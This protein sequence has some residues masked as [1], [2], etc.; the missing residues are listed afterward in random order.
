MEAKPGKEQE[1]ATFLSGAIERVHES[2]PCGVL[3]RCEVRHPRHMIA[4][5]NSHLMSSRV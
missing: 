3:D 2:I 4:D 1:V 5:S